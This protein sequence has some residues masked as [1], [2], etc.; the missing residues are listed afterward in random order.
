MCGCFCSFARTLLKPV[1]ALVLAFQISPL[2]SRADAPQVRVGFSGIASGPWAAWGE[3][4]NNGFFLAHAQSRTPCT[5]DFQDDQSDPRKTLTNVQ[6]FLADKAQ[7]L[8]IT[9]MESL[10][11]VMPL[12]ARHN[13]PVFALGSISEEILDRYPHIVAA[14][15]TYA[16]ADPR[17]IA[18][19][20]GSAG[21]IKTVAIVNGTNSVGEAMG[22]RMK[23]EAQRRGIAV[24][25][26]FSVPLDTAEYHSIIALLQRDNPNALFVHQGEQN[27]LTFVRQARQGGFTGQ[28]YTISAIE[29]D[30]TRKAMGAYLEGVRYVFPPASTDETPQA[31]AFRKSYQSRYGAMP[32]VNAAIGFDAFRIIERAL[33][34]CPSAALPCLSSFFRSKPTFEGAAGTLTIDEHRG[35]LRPLG[36]QEIRDGK[37][38]WVTKKI[39]L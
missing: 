12:A 37:F 7:L 32:A 33:A 21:T 17:F 3:N 34:A 16:D 39:A 18:A 4:L 38:V 24:T 15:D 20:M 29:N 28:I 8:I 35:P 23:I 22:A 14:L 27:L 25:R 2:A 5:V 30:E 10:H 13:V 11:A 19:Y 26:Q 31:V 9:P 36:L 6:K 1:F